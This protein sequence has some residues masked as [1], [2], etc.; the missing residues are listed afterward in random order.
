MAYRYQFFG[1]YL[2]F[3]F[4]IVQPNCSFASSQCVLRTVI[5]SKINTSLRAKTIVLIYLTNMFCW[6]VIVPKRFF[7]IGITID[8]IYL[9]SELI[10]RNCWP[11][12]CQVNRSTFHLLCKC[13]LRSIECQRGF[14]TLRYCIYRLAI[15]EM[16]MQHSF[17]LMKQN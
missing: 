9:Q 13:I 12:T 3:C 16:A 7:F 6:L 4:C 1:I 17:E 2:Y 8:N 10:T 5:T 14:R 11:H 15:F